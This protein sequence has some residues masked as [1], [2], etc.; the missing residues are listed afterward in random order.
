MALTPGHIPAFSGSS[1]LFNGEDNDGGNTDNHDDVVIVQ[2]RQRI[3]ENDDKQQ[4]HLSCHYPCRP[5]IV[6]N[7]PASRPR[8]ACTG[9]TTCECNTMRPWRR[10]HHRHHCRRPR[11]LLL[12]RPSW[13]TSRHTYPSTSSSTLKTS[14]EQLMTFRTNT[15][16]TITMKHLV[17][18]N[19][20][21]TR[22]PFWPGR[23]TK[24]LDLKSCEKSSFKI[25][26]FALFCV[27]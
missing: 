19:Y 9:N 25:P 23:A 5:R 24:K 15:Q 12:R 10:R 14:C 11:L 22:P 17:I 13:F 26:L 6:S 3:V 1:T 27:I 16:G 20:R 7:R 21:P 8:A 2:K 4:Q 18:D